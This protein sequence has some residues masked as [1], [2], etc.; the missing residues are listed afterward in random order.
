MQP[1]K[2]LKRLLLRLHVLDLNVTHP[3]NLLV[4]Q[5]AKGFIKEGLTIHL[6]LETS[7]LR[8]GVSEWYHEPEYLI[9]E[10][11]SVLHELPCQ[12]LSCSGPFSVQASITLAHVLASSSSLQSLD[13]HFNHM[14]VDGI[15]AIGGEL[16]SN[17]SLQR[18]DLDNLSSS[19]ILQSALSV[20]RLEQFELIKNT[21]RR[22]RP[23]SRL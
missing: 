9:V 16:A 10:N 11:L 20:I 19:K 1:L 2:N 14:D 18:L 21:I 15:K 6:V 3:E 7:I 22:K 5:V 23:D 17:F 12:I 13:L 8:L 4:I